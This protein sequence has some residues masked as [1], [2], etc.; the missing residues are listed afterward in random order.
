MVRRSSSARFMAGAW[1]FPGGVVDPEDSDPDSLAAIEGL[2]PESGLGPWV[3]AAFREVVEETGLWLVDP[4]LVEPLDTEPV[5][6]VVKRTGRRF[7]M[8]NVA[9]FA[10]WITPTMVPVRFDARFFI[11]AIDE[12]VTPVPDLAEIDAAEFVAPAEALRRAE[13]GEWLVPFPTQRTLDQL[14]EFGSVRAALDEWQNREVVPVQPRMRVADDGSLEV[15]MPNDPGF[16]DLD[17][18]EPDPDVLAKAAKAAADKGRPIAEVPV[19][20]D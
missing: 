20:G 17:D 13:A 16:D 15:V 8:A 14:L 9:Y 2:S 7:G 3:A 11:V 1:V 4:P 19:D 10:N 6:E 5:F 18:A 12:L